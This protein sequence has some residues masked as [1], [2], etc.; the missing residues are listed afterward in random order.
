MSEE[1]HKTTHWRR[2][3]EII[4]SLAR[5]E[6][7]EDALQN[8]NTNKIICYSAHGE[9]LQ[10]ENSE[11]FTKGGRS[12]WVSD[13]SY[14]VY[15]IPKIGKE[16]KV[17]GEYYILVHNT[18]FDYWIFGKMTYSINRN[19]TKRQ[20]RLVDRV[21]F[22]PYGRYQVISTG[23]D[24]NITRTTKGKDCE[25]GFHHPKGSFDTIGARKRAYRT[26]GAKLVGSI[27]GRNQDMK[28]VK[29]GDAVK[30]YKKKPRNNTKRKY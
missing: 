12:C 6:G 5:F 16:Y 15:E 25:F 28:T 13:N 3:R 29:G 23:R 19:E 1:L 27:I 22:L 7:V 21:K 18:D 11:F 14:D 10:G 8:Y 26:S 17:E 4:K 9:Q 24:F 30:I 2:L 20:G